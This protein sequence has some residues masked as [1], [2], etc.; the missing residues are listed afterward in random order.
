[1]K[2]ILSNHEMADDN[3]FQIH[4]KVRKH[5]LELGLSQ[6]ELAENTGLSLSTIVKIEAGLLPN[7]TIK[8]LA[9][10]AHEF[11]LIVDELL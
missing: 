7:P 9:I 2:R 8:T 4:R 6:K 11:D 1:M 3:L 10:L 5:R